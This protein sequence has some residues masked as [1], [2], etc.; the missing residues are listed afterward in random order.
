IRCGGHARMRG[1]RHEESE[2]RAREDVVV[3]ENR[4][5]RSIIQYAIAVAEELCSR[6]RARV[7]RALQ[8]LGNQIIKDPG[9]VMCVVLLAA[10]PAGAAPT[11]DVPN[12]LTLSQAVTIALSNNSILRTAQGRLEQ[13]SGQYAQSRGVLLPQVDVRPYQA[14]MT[15]NLRGIGID[16]PTVP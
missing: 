8:A 16:I 6:A 10:M 15:I 7:N 3:T 13:A 12:P 11:Q 2:R 5:L 14:Y 1:A 9:G 4:L